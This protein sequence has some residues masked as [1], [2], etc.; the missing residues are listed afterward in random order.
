MKMIAGT[1]AQSVT[2]ILGDRHICVAESAAVGQP[3]CTQ[4]NR[5]A[6]AVLTELGAGYP[7]AAAT[8]EIIIGFDCAQDRSE[9]VHTRRCFVAKPSGERFRQMRNAAS[10]PV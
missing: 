6:L 3:E 1:F 10:A 8:F 7:V 2:K 5:I 4:V 9:L